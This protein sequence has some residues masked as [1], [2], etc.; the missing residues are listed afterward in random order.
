MYPLGLIARD[1]MSEAQ[2][3]SGGEVP[4][5]LSFGEMG[6]LAP[7]VATDQTLKRT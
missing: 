2:G 3:R 1:L 4:R 5:C 6:S 7:A